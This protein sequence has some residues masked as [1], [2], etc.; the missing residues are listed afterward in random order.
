MRPQTE[1]MLMTM[2]K[3][4]SLTRINTHLIKRINDAEE[5]I[6]SAPSHADICSDG[7]GINSR[8]A[9]AAI[10]VGFDGDLLYPEAQEF[11]KEFPGEITY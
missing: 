6:Q 4:T 5:M 2:L 9:L 10:I 11:M 7:T 3:V 8:Q 1:R